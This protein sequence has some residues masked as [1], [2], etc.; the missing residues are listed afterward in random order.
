MS[1]DLM[2]KE[3]RKLLERTALAEKDMKRGLSELMYA[4]T[5]TL[6]L[7]LL[8]VIDIICLNM[9]TTVISIGTLETIYIV[10]LS[11]STRLNVKLQVI[12]NKI[13]FYS[14]LPSNGIFDN[15]T[16]SDFNSHRDLYS[17]QI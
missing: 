1:V 2:K 5:S 8:K 17:L 11:P 14:L 12:L 10:L 7:I 3:S 16:T 9:A 13:Y 6:P 4:P 15:A